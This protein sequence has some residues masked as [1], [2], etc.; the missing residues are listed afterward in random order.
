MYHPTLISDPPRPR[1]KFRGDGGAEWSGTR[2]GVYVGDGDGVGA[3]RS[4]TGAAKTFFE[5]ALRL[6]LVASASEA[7]DHVNVIALKLSAEKATAPSSK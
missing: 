1:K 7:I 5:V 4:G 2:A 3:E 6:P